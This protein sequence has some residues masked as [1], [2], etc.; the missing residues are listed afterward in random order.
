MHPALTGLITFLAGFVVTYATMPYV[1]RFARR[2]RAIDRP[3]H[4]KST[5]G[6]LVPTLGGLGV[7]F[8]TWVAVFGVSFFASGGIEGVLGNRLLWVVLGSGVVMLATG[9]FDDRFSLRAGPK[10]LVQFGVALGIVAS[11]YTFEVI[12][13][14][15][16]GAIELRQLSVPLTILWIVGVTNAINL[17][18]GINGLAGGVSML[19]AA[20]VAVI[21]GMGGNTE[22]VIL[23]A[24]VSGGCAGFLPFN[25]KTSRVFMGDA[26]SLFLGMTLAVLSLGSSSK[27][28]VAGSMLVP[29][30]LMG[31]PTLDTILVMARRMIRGK[32]MFNG[33]RGH[34]HHRLLA[35][36]LSHRQSAVMLWVFCLMFCGLAVSVSSNYDRVVMIATI[37]GLVLV[38]LAGAFRLGYHKEVFTK[39]LGSH[40]R[41]FMTLRT[42]TKLAKLEMMSAS[43]QAELTSVVERVSEHFSVEQ[44]RVHY[45]D[46][47]DKLQRLSVKA[48]EKKNGGNGHSGAVNHEGRLRER[49]RYPKSRMTVNVV[50]RFNGLSEEMK[51]EHRSHFSQ[52]MSVFSQSLIKLSNGVNGVEVKEPGDGAD[53][54]V[55]RVYTPVVLK[56][57]SGRVR[58]E[59]MSE[60]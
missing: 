10:F 60:V 27:S 44:I 45:L 3:S 53:R 28:A 37:A 26:G 23:A 2:I 48:G 42:R 34:I 49:Y 31:Y 5:S 54:D 55:E 21:A 8:G 1:I 41:E 14:P 52:M 13:L 59:G 6:Q 58:R 50:F 46:G 57:E 24:A 51:M 25:F 30:L 33:D 16:I 40:R 56:T 17:I 9:A 15:W 20:S 11:G 35:R 29:L 12:S 22:V 43:D 19:V 47:L 39:R 18:D 32:S 36:G 4:R 38:V 7:F